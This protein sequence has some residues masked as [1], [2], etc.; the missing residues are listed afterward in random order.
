MTDPEPQREPCERQTSFAF[1][2][3]GLAVFHT[4]DKLH[5]GPQTLEVLREAL[6]V[7][8]TQLNH[9]ETQPAYRIVSALLTSLDDIQTERDRDTRR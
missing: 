9:A 7:Q 2:A 8:W 6:E 5:P 4:L 1:Q 3:L